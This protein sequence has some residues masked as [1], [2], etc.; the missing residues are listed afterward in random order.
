MLGWIAGFP[1]VGAMI[2]FALALGLA[3][4]LGSY[5]ERRISTVVT[6]LRTRPVSPPVDLPD[7]T[8]ND[9]ISHLSR[10][11][12]HFLR[13]VQISRD[14]DREELHR[15]AQLLDRMRTGVMRVDSNG[16]VSYANVAAG[17]LFGGRNPTGRSFLAVS[18][19]HELNGLLMHC[20]KTGEEQ[21][22][23]FEIKNEGLVVD[24]HL[25][26]LGTSP[27]EALVVL[28]DVTELTRLQTLRRDFVA[29]V[30]HE[31]RTPLSTIKILTETLLTMSDDRPDETRF[32]QK[33]DDE[34]DAMTTL[35][36][37]LLN[38]ARLESQEH[39]LAVRPVNVEHLIADVRERMLPIADQRG[40]TL[41]SESSGLEAGG[42]EADDHRLGQ[43][44]VNLLNNAIFH[45]P[46]GGT[47]RIYA[48]DVGDSVEF[49]VSDTGSGIDPEN[50]NRIWERF[51]KVD[52]SR[53]N[54][55]SGLGLAIVKHIVLAHGGTVS[56]SSQPGAGSEFKI[57]IPR[58][59]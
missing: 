50:L 15:Y 27:R 16:T 4:F 49:G 17:A 29:N 28:Q 34:I 53:A 55:G 39:Q 20:L 3:L 33:V 11:A 30:S 40:V 54:A 2:G 7:H 18:R 19:D 6:L 9:Q 51:Y 42:F 22:H 36:N 12:T 31:L 57:R 52:R 23:T 5:A 38:L 48:T 32:L 37:D 25:I 13:E 47:V 35:V 21:Q 24:A 45:T 46:A 58:T 26:R 14:S 8:M 44:L 56:A 10:A 41:V 1:G 43:A 59:A